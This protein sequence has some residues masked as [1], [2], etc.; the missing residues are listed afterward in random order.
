MLPSKDNA[1]HEL[2][3]GATLKQWKPLLASET[4]AL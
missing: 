4:D 3:E 2:L 1:P